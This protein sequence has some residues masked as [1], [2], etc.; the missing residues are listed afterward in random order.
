M[1]CGYGLYRT[2]THTSKHKLNY[3]RCIGSDGYRRLNGPLCTHR[4]IRQDYLDEFVWNEAIRLL[5]NPG[6]IQAEID[7][8]RDAARNAGPLRKR[9]EAQTGPWDGIIIQGDE[10]LN[11]GVPHRC[12]G[13]SRL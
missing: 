3:Y 7:R 5:D 8:R 13:L 6:L 4:P 1:K 10:Y 9:E 2:S 11:N 12:G